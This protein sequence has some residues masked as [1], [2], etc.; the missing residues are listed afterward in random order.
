[1]LLPPPPLP[2]LSAADRVPPLAS[3]SPGS[4]WL[5]PGDPDPGGERVAIVCEALSAASH[6]EGLFFECVS[7][8]PFD[9]VLPCPPWHAVDDL[10]LRALP[11]SSCTSCPAPDALARPLPG[12]LRLAL[13]TPAGRSSHQGGGGLLQA[14][15]PSLNPP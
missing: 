6:I 13:S 10:H 15:E 5:S 12:Q 11:N 14:M 8:L 2:F 3:L 9:R 4:G 1:M 7:T